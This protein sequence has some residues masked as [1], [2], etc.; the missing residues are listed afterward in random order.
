MTANTHIEESILREQDSLER[1]NEKLMKMIASLMQRVEANEKSDSAFAH[2]QTA[3]TLEAQ[4][5]HRTL[6]LE[7]AL[8]ELNQSRARAEELR[9]EAEEARRD[10]AD[11]IE[12]IREGFA[13][14]D[15]R[16]V[17]VHAN[18]RF[19]KM[20]PDIVST[21]RPGLR[22]EDY[23]KRVAN[24]AEIVFP[25]GMGRSDWLEERLSI[26]NQH[27]KH[28]LVELLGDRWV[29]ISE[30]ST[31]RGAT[32][33]M[34]TEVTDMVRLERVERR[35]LLDAQQELVRATLEHIDQGVLIADEKRLIAGTNSKMREHL[36]LPLE[37]FVS[38]YRL[39][40]VIDEV[41]NQ[42]IF[43]STQDLFKL[44]DWMRNTE[45]SRTFRGALEREDGRMFDV[46]AQGMPDGGFVVSSTDVT[47]ERIAAIELL[48]AKSFLE[49]RVDERTEELSVARDLAEQASLAKTR[50]LAAT[51]HDLLQPINA[52]KLFITSLKSTDINVHQGE[53]IDNISKAFNSVEGMLRGLLDISRLDSPSPIEKTPISVASLFETLSVEFSPIAAAK[54]LEL[55]FRPCQCYV[56]SEASSLRRIAQNLIGNA[57][58][59]TESGGVLIGTRKRGDHI[60]LEIFDTG[61]GIS[62]S[63]IE[64]MYN[65]FQRFDRVNEGGAGMGLG[66]SIVQRSC[67]LLG[68][69]LTVKS[70]VGRGTHFRVKLEC[71]SPLGVLPLPEPEQ[72]EF[73]APRFENFLV[74]V[75]DND[76]SIL[77][78]M[79]V[80]L[81]GWGA[82]PV[83]A[84]SGQE[85]LSILEELDMAADVALV[86]YQ[87]ENN[88]NGLDA[89]EKLREVHPEMAAMLITANRDKFTTA[90]AIE[91][92]IKINHKPIDI[93]RLQRDLSALDA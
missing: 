73:E 28:F 76:E 12:A 4:V 14:F 38:G 79:E 52:A 81:E 5:R 8:G 7:S 61:S 59:Y 39:A 74:L 30:Q 65:E 56:I 3:A 75:I 48:E 64:V 93:K 72:K 42:Q 58:K 17:L 27:H 49:Q 60:F 36:A 66:L 45:R 43:R 53:I 10:L 22:F 9:G 83:T 89:I 15:A 78:A 50:F 26:H 82:T 54:G 1:R 63:E 62:K 19:A 40:A 91:M 20:F 92:G 71:A 44:V 25:E 24:S 84:R 86:D 47:N 18:N 55:R 35:K 34:Q 11:A 80:L 67:A 2:F 16:N 21:I 29:Q 69:E 46:F 33:I 77:R 70:E 31:A 68:H 57:I 88:E 6:A 32:T 90:R 87:L 85:A 13:L 23:I 41:S 37:F 51:S